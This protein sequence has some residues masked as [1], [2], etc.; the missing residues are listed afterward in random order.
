M[1]EATENTFHFELVSPAKKLAE[2]PAYQVIVPGQDGDLGV[3]KGH[4]S[5]VVSVRAGVVEILKTPESTPEKVFVVGGF[6][7]ISSDNCTVL[8]EEATPVEE[9]DKSEI[10]AQIS[11]IETKLSSEQTDIEKKRLSHKLDIEKAKLVACG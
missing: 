10:E 1:T 8:A 4:S 11:E 9:L 7:D 3:R 6:A 5:F 2:T